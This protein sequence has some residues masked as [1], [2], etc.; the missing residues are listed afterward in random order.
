MTGKS[1]RAIFTSSYARGKVLPTKEM[2]IEN[3]KKCR[4]NMANRTI[5]AVIY[6]SSTTVE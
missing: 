4:L 2:E 3:K 5:I 6:T 1:A